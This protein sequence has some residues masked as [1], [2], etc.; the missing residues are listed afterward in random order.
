M[1]GR[2]W[3][4]VLPLTAPLSLNDREHWAPKA[5]KIAQ[6]RSDVLVLCRA[7]KIPRLERVQVQL[8]YRPRD[9][10]TRDA[11]NLVATLKP[12]ADGV[13][14]AK[15]IPDDCE[16]YLTPVMPKLLPPVP[17]KGPLLAL[18]IRDLGPA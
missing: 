2:T 7:K 1:S 9:R 13:V 11:E 10:R 16:P 18:V 15:V 3:T 4:I 12:C 14:D 6:L 8:Y 17:G 5:R